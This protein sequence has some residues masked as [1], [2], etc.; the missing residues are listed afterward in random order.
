MSSKKTFLCRGVTNVTIIDIKT[1]YAVIIMKAMAII[2]LCITGAVLCSSSS[3]A[4]FQAGLVR[5][6]LMSWSNNMEDF[7][8]DMADTTDKGT[9]SIPAPYG[10]GSA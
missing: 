6:V 9:I 1:K 7:A 8:K 4:S 2:R 10:Q 3:C 5:Q